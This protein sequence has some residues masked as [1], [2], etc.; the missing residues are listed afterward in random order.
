MKVVKTPIEDLLIIEPEIH[1]DERGFFFEAFHLERY[2]KLLGID[3]DFVQDNYSHSMQNVLRGLHFQKNN[4]QGKLVRAVKGK[5]F[6]VAVDIRKESDSF[7]KWF[8]LELSEDNKKQLWV[9]PRFAHGFLV[10]SE[11]ADLEYKCTEYYKPEDEGC[12]I[13]NDQII[14]IEW[15]NKNPLLSSKDSLGLTAENLFNL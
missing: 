1:G 15:P 7:L 8:G 14:G 5:I 9:P 4:P 3:H 6:D 2:R 11:F 12:L 13:W 10:L